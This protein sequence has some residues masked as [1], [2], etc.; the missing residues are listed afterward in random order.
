MIRSLVRVKAGDM[1]SEKPTEPTTMRASPEPASMPRRR[2]NPRAASTSPPPISQAG[3]I[4]RARIGVTFDAHDERQRP[5]QRP[6]SG[7]ERGH[8]EHQLQVLRD[9]Q[10]AAEEHEDPDA[11]RRQRGAERR[12]P[13]QGQV[14]ERVG[15]PALAS[16]EHVAQ[17]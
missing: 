3:S 16:Y 1:P 15:Q 13:E 8:A 17:S 9:E 2:P 4:R 6:Q 5:R 7:L 11:V 10:E 12:D 14:D